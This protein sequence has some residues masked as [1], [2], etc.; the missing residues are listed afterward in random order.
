MIK[1]KRL[2]VLLL[3]I[4]LMNIP[5]LGVNAE[6]D[7][8]NIFSTDFDS[9]TIGKELP[10]KETLVSLESAYPRGNGRI[11]GAAV[12]DVKD[13]DHG[14]SLKFAEGGWH[15]LNIAGWDNITEPLLFS[16]D[17]LEEGQ[18]TIRFLTNNANGAIATI[19]GRD[20]RPDTHD[21]TDAA[22]TKNVVELNKWTPVEIYIDTPNQ[23]FAFFIDGKLIGGLHEFY[24]EASSIES[25]QIQKISGGVMYIDNL[26]L[27]KVTAPP[28]SELITAS[29]PAED[30]V[31]VSSESVKVNFSGAV[32][33]DTLTTENIKVYA[34]GNDTPLAGVTL[35]NPT[36]YSV[37][38]KFGEAIAE[39]KEYCIDLSG[40]K[41]VFGQSMAEGAA[42]IPF[43]GY[44]GD[45]NNIFSTDFDSYT[46]GKELP[47]K[48]TLVSLETAYPRGNGRIAGAAVG[49]VKDDDHGT[50]LKF[51]E[52][53]WHNL[54]IAG[55][56]N[57]TEPLLFS[58]DF[59]EEGQG[60][61][62]FLTNNANGAIATIAGRDAR[63]DTHDGTDAA[64]TKNVVELNKWTPVEIYIDTP[65][66]K[67]AFFIDGKLIGGLHEFYGEA[68]SIESIQIQ[69]ISG[70]VMYIDNLSLKKVTAPA[71]SVS[72]D[73]A[74]VTA[75]YNSGWREKE[76]IAFIAAYDK[77]GVLL[78]VEL[79]KGDKGTLTLPKNTSAVKYKAFLWGEN[80]NPLCEPQELYN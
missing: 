26:S 42:Q 56:D 35:E 70:G 66:Q 28:H 15:N 38:V 59:L 1:F 64:F 46:I 55:W 77:D 4:A 36:A 43:T 67:F 47:V 39:N 52:G 62:R 3:C 19:A 12:G 13:D 80:Q 24:G 51:A 5:V 71:L 72:A 44:K 68:S 57:I 30:K 8:N 9:Y 74:N 31:S 23:K 32:D 14:T 16:F 41:G 58:F 61:I 34:E 7:E 48:E 69:K 40:V 45:E 18:G 76:A 49:D 79:A 29:I 17:F 53:G 21:G 11:A 10:V 37:D 54:N 25:I 33:V 63:P 78:N 20:A 65:N 2:P 50:S 27:K 73:D 60:T 22:F 6:G 75:V